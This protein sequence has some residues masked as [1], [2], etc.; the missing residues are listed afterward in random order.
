MHQFCITFKNAW[1]PVTCQSRLHITSIPGYL[2]RHDLLVDL[3]WLIS[4][5]WGVPSGHLVDQ[6]SQCPPVHSFV[7]ALAE[8]SS[9]NKVQRLSLHILCK[10]WQLIQI[11]RQVANSHTHY[12]QHTILDTM[13]HLAEDDLW[14]QVLW[15]STQCP[16]PAF[17]SFG[18]A[19]VCDLKRTNKG[20]RTM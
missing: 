8:Y 16:G 7:V 6:D 5:E 18:K 20:I 10:H 11:Y 2:A 4:E 1:C 15:S 9:E 13:A 3:D 14:S 17:D 12:V 19:K